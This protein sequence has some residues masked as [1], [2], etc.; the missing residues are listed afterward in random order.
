MIS[1]LI[2]CA[3]GILEICVGTIL[4][5]TCKHPAGLKLAKFLIRDG[6]DNIVEGIKATVQGREIDLKEFGQRKAVKL[7]FFTI[8]F[9]VQSY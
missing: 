4:I 2:V 5:F 3:L 9:D 7:F 6:I 1:N 8:Q